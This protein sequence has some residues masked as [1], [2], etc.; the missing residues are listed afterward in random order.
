MN[1]N[2]ICLCNIKF[3]KCIINRKKWKIIVVE[4]WLINVDGK[5]Y[6]GNSIVMVIRMNISE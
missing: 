5:K 1:I 6:L 4:F 2:I 3:R